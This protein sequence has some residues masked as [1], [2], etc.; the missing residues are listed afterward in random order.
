[1]TDLSDQLSPEHYSEIVV[2][3]V[4]DPAVA[5]ARG[6]RTLT[7]TGPERDELAALGFAPAQIERDDA[8]PLL[9]IP[10]KDAFGAVKGHQIKPA[11]P[12]YLRD[13]ESN[14][15]RPLK[16]ETPKGAMSMVDVPDFTRGKFES[17]GARLW[18]TEGMKKVDALVSQGAAALGLTGVYNWRSKHATLGDWEDI[19]LR[20]R[21]VF[22]CF[23][24]DAAGNRNVQQAMARLGAWLKSKR[25]RPLY[26]VVP[27]EVNG[28]PTKG[29]DDYF[30]AGGD[31]KD[32]AA[33]A[34][35]TAPGAGS[36][37]AGFTDALLVERAVDEALAGKFAWAQGLGWLGWNG[38]VW[39][40]VS[41]V[42][43]LE[44]VRQWAKAQ[45]DAVCAKQ[46]ANPAENLTA[47]VAGWRGVLAKAK[48]I[49]LRDLSR[50][51]D[52]VLQ[53]AKDFDSDPDLLTCLNGTIHLPTG[54][55]RPHSPDDLI[56]KSADAAYRPRARH[57][58]FTK[59]LTAIP[60]DLHLWYQ[61]RMGQA[62]TGYPT[63]D[64]KLVIGQGSGSNGK[65][66]LSD[67]FRRT[68]GGYG[69]LVS[70]RALLANNDAHPTELMDFRGAR[71]AVMEETPEARHLN[72]KRLKDSV[73]TPTMKARRMRQDPVEFLASHSLFINTNYTPVVVETDHGTWR[74][75]ALLPF[76]YTFRAPGKQLNG[77]LERT[78][79][80][81]LVYA[82]SDPEVR[83]A[84]LAWMVEGAVSWYARERRMMEIPGRVDDAT[85][86]WR[87][88]TDLILGFCDDRLEFETAAFTQT[89]DMLSAFN[90]WSS[91]RGHKPWNDRTFASRF[92]DHENVR[93]HNVK[94]TR[95]RVG[96]KV[97][98][99]WDGVKLRND[100]GPFGNGGEP[101]PDPEP[102]D[103]S[104]LQDG[105]ACGECGC[106]EGA[107]VQEGCMGSDPAFGCVD[108][109]TEFD[110]SEPDPEDWVDPQPQPD[111]YG[112]GSI[113]EPGQ[114]PE[115]PPY[116]SEPVQACP[117]LSSSRTPA[118]PV[119]VGFDLETADADKLFVGGYE[120]PFVRLCGDIWDGDEWR[121]ATQVYE[122]PQRLIAS[123]TADADTIYGHN[124]LG[125]DLLALA[126]HHG[127]DYDALAAKAVD[128]LPLERLNDPP[129]SKGMPSGYYG[130]DATAQRLGHTGKTDDLKALARKHGGFDKIPTDDPEYRAYLE[131]DLHAT[132]FVYDDLVHGA[133]MSEY[134][135]REMKVAAVQNRMTLNG[136]RVDRAELESRAQAENAKRL[137]A[138]EILRDRY[139]VPTHRP[140][141]FKLKLKRDWPE[142]WS[143]ADVKMLDGETQEREG[144]AVR[145]PGER[146]DM[147]WATD[148]GRAAIIEAFA[149]AGAKGYPT[150]AKGVLALGKDAL[151]EET[152]Y[153]PDR[154]RTFPGMLKAFG[155][156]PEV[157]ALVETLLQATGARMKY[158]EI[159]KWTTDRDRVHAWV[160]EAQGSGRWAMT[161]PSITNMGARGAAA[162]ERAVLIADPGEIL[163][164]CDLSQVDMRAVAGLSQDREYM[165]LFEPGRDAHM[166]MAEVYFGERT[167]EAR[168]RT[169]AI[170]HGLN[171]GESASRVA[172]SNGLDQAIVDAAV[173]A[174]AEAYP[175]VIEWTD[176][177]RAIAASGQLLDNGF[178]RMMRANPDRA[179]T[180]APALCGQ[181]A[182]RDIMCESLLRLVE[183]A[184]RCG[185]NVRPH[186]RAVVH[187][188]VVLSVPDD[189][190]GEWQQ[191]L[192]EAFT[193]E[194]KGVPILCDLGTPAKSWVDCK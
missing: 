50:G 157:R 151:G 150:T 127:A 48:I 74:R 188:E 75:L 68:F 6:Y 54:E 160:G 117:E 57:P 64:H 143:M 94:Q 190:V 134:A 20:D 129:L 53:S 60:A 193:W 114:F 146:Y 87:I 92:A 86:R 40:E 179:H 27:P 23:D 136:W 17:E 44:A 97:Q 46:A 56:T 76:P 121:P 176:E 2:S 116:A 138:I 185:L 7:G 45:F 38:R 49:G 161:K 88:Q 43:P 70:D 186:L 154:R 118:I 42:E 173:R 3:S 174:R 11:N 66:T 144:F 55:L 189:M 113:T 158:A 4:V 159:L 187:D 36:K 128:T 156:I 184:D 81:D 122:D 124:I 109:C 130:L 51:V 139:G 59:A 35:E 191:L 142:P 16:Y 137:D 105:P 108:H 73:G 141:R 41:D 153:C 25:A 26:I 102:L 9:L 177:V 194:W 14:E 58:L 5:A 123:L 115:D 107:H 80:P 152:W 171:Y 32:L 77:P 168:N 78:G 112:Y 100:S 120:G 175:R 131:G 31:I 99:G 126:Y 163:V 22:V 37:D 89:T 85:R 155:H 103:L 95:R 172:E 79:D 192:K 24:A 1:M 10:M 178:G 72:V 62:L 8:Y 182:A 21:T 166:E 125:F 140:D 98:R 169:K 90:E 84:A 106:A 61:D 110:G 167:K 101:D 15:P 67:I 65:S 183:L 165:K 104:Y 71:F 29:V 181:G 135:R 111:L 30:A 180:Q 52:G 34:T 69:V 19:P 162:E 82:A 93:Q 12:R 147:P 170:N 28:T 164:T 33:L 133:G 18:I 47:Q 63:P 13:R 119:A 145:I 39:A 132:K 149:K 91:E 83:A 96:G 148:A